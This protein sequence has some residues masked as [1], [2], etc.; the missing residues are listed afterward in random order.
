MS[1]LAMKQRS[2]WSLSGLLPAA[3]GLILGLAFLSAAY[4]KVIDPRETQRA[5]EHLLGGVGLAAEP[6]VRALIL[7]EI[8][9]GT[10]LVA[11]VAR[12]AMLWL[13]ATTLFVLSGWILYLIVADVSVGCIC[14]DE[15]GVNGKGSIGDSEDDL[16]N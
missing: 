10:L 12:R 15:S 16:S 13:A 14:A 6:A 4:L 9:L 8:L 1:V 3:A 2:D 5:L 11:G 7:G